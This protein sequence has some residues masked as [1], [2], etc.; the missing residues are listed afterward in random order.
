MKGV[1]S[2][3]WGVIKCDCLI[4]NGLRCPTR[5]I[6]TF[7]A[8]VQLKSYPLHWFSPQLDA[9]GRFLFPLSWETFLERQGK[10][11]FFHNFA[12]K[13][14]ARQGNGSASLLKGEIQTDENVKDTA[15][16]L[17][18]DLD[19]L[20]SFLRQKKKNMKIFMKIQSIVHYLAKERWV[21]WA[22]LTEQAGNKPLSGKNKCN[23]TQLLY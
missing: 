17:D 3:S 13:I 23:F 1:N 4:Q 15:D 9:T 5:A 14:R 6:C 22:H 11:S 20:V 10:C 7:T 2:L 12:Y 18:L 21:L 19:L 8:E 16:I